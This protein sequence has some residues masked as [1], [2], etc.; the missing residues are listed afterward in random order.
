MK[1]TFRL[2]LAPHFRLHLRRHV[3]LFPIT[4][5]ASSMHGGTKYY[6]PRKSTNLH[7]SLYVIY[8]AR[9]FPTSPFLVT[10]STSSRSLSQRRSYKHIHPFLASPLPVSLFGAISR[11]YQRFFSDVPLVFQTFLFGSSSI[12]RGCIVADHVF[13]FSSSGRTKDLQMLYT[14]SFTVFLYVSRLPRLVTW[15]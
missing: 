12:N 5:P 1:T 4:S 7:P 13:S 14:T 3:A 11:I 9:N 2:F 15:L 8:D 10:N 6:Y